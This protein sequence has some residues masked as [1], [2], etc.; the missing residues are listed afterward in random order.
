M[1]S[2]LA[3]SHGLNGLTFKQA[4][5]KIVKHYAINNVVTRA[6]TLAVITVFK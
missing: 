6:L 4:C 5:S 1:R 3:D 2:A